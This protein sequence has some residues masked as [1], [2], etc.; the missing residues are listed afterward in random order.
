MLI[1]LSFNYGGL[2]SALTFVTVYNYGAISALTF[3]TMHNYGVISALFCFPIR[4]LI[5]IDTHL[6]PERP[7]LISVDLVSSNY[8]VLELVS[9]N[10]KVLELVS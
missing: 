4:F 6:A 9:S 5:R 2:I 7:W 3:V 8:T 10:C 1:I